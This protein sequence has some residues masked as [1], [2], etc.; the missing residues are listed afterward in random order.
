[1]VLMTTCLQKDLFLTGEEDSMI[2]E[3]VWIEVFSQL[4]W[5][6]LRVMLGV[7]HTL[8]WDGVLQHG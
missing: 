8:V 2:C 4:R 1:M 6:R 5:G 7:H 3:I